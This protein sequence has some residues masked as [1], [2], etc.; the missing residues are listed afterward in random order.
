MIK[1]IGTDIVDVSRMTPSIANRILSEPELSLYEGFSAESRKVEF[2]AGRFAIKEAISK[3]IGPIDF[4]LS[5]HEMM[6]LNDQDGRPYLVCEK[7]KNL[8]ILLSISHER[9]YAVGFCVIEEAD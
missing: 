8:R 4:P 7:L 6:V 9:H 5:F 3:A 1:G 2:L